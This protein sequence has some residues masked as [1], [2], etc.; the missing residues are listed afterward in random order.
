MTLGCINGLLAACGGDDDA[1]E[2]GSGT[3]ASGSS[4]SSSSGTQG[5]GT[6]GSASTGEVVIYTWYQPWIDEVVP[7]F[8][9]ETGI[10]VV[11]LGSY[12]SN[13]EWWAKLGAGESFDFF[14][15][16]TEY[17]QRAMAADYLSPIDL[18]QIPNY[19]NIFDDF[20]HLDYFQE[21]DQTFA[22][23]LTRVYYTLTYNRDEFP[24]PPT[25]WAV[26][27]DEQ[28][29]GRI[30][31]SDSAFDR[32]THA[33][34]YIGDD[35]LNP[36]RWDEIKDALIEQKNL[37][38]TYWS[39]YQTGMQ[40]FVND[41]VVVGQLTNGRTRMAQELG[42]PVAWTIPSEGGFVFVDTL[43]IPKTARNPENAHTFLNFLL[44]EDISLK[45]MQGMSYDTVN[46]ASHALLSDE[47]RPIFSPPE[48]SKLIV[49]PDMPADVRNRMDE[50][51]NEVRLS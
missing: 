29:S 17:V 37:V 31:M 47:E 34:L 24:D 8:E 21:G 41:E 49:A 18:E 3:T 35:P 15:P 19:S 44:R 12:S 20:Q 28:Y 32:V 1:A 2:T 43:A 11:Q 48:G 26:T 45:L 33:A 50:I 23:P 42:T 36:S 30:T 51:W 7:I 10:K 9:Q 4:S 13:D 40:L 6:A 25:S 5:Q 14:I 22:V 39:D 27:W 38:R 16:T 46:A